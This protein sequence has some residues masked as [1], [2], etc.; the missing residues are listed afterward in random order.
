MAITVANYQAELGFDASEF[1]KGMSDSEKGYSSF[2]GKMKSLGGGL[3]KGLTAAIGAVTT[4]VTALVATTADGIKKTAEYGDNVDKMSQKIGISKQAYQEWDFILQHCGANVDGLQASMKTLSNKA[5]DGSDSFAKLGISMDDVAS[6]S[7]EDLFS[8]VVS[9]LQ[10]MEEGT[11]RTAI[12]SELLGKSATELGALFNTTAEDTEAMRQQVH[13]LG[14][15]MSDDAVS[16]AATF[17]DSLQNL[18][19]AISGLSRGALAEFLPSVTSIMDGLTMIFSGDSSGIELINQGISGFITNLSNIIPQ[20][21]EIGSNIILTLMSAI[22][23]NL[24][25]LIQSATGIIITLVNGIIEL[26]PSIATAAIQI[27]TTIAQ[28][29]ADNIPTLVTTVVNVLLQ[30]VQTLLDNLP[31]LLDAVLQIILG[32]VQGILDAIPIIIEALPQVISSI[33]DFLIGA[34]PQI[35][36]AGIKLLTSLVQA[37]PQIIN[38]IVAA[39]PQIIDSLITAIIGS[40]PQ[41]VQAG[42]DLLVSLIKNL[43]TIIK[44]ILKAIPQI[45]TS[46]VN[47]IANNI[48][49]IIQAGVELL[50]SLV[51]NLPKIIVEV[52]KAIPQIITSLVSAIIKGVP[53]IANAG[54][55]LVKGLFNGISNAVGWLYG[56]LKGWVSSVLSYIKGLFGIHSPSKETAV[57]GKYIAEGLGVGIEDN[58]DAANA[59]SEKLSEN[60]LNTFEDMANDITN[61]ENGLLDDVDVSARKKVTLSTVY[62]N[63]ALNGSISNSVA[64]SGNTL[65]DGLTSLFDSFIGKTETMLNKLI[66]SVSVGSTN[67][68]STS[69]ISTVINM[70]DISVSGVIDKGAAEQ[71]NDIAKKQ[72]EDVKNYVVESEK[73]TYSRVMEKAKRDKNF[74]SMIQDMTFGNATGKS[75]LTKNKYKY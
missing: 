65:T 52:V 26:F 50:V 24:P 41:I 34:I 39:I 16:A 1:K 6:M 35:I 51:K 10:N 25:A 73:Y 13:D 3:A 59:A 32:L 12:A 70:G 40:I 28:G 72:A 29:I 67:G 42:I 46:L 15:V 64:I 17:Q 55:N 9:G 61:I 8:S 5:Q 2:T 68:V 4:G 75:S 36:D 33:I 47:A 31:V 63:A 37:L 23:Q 45:I 7:T 38:A 69:N 43:P 56:K 60:V 74:E 30:I 57:F 14:G 21:L 18:Q 44:T 49:A 19:T 48:P 54:L 53:Q 62:D 66:D 58:A 20:I 71:V 27:I 11:E 22:T